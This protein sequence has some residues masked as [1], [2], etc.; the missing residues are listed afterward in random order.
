MNLIYVCALLI[1]GTDRPDMNRSIPNPHGT[2]YTYTAEQIKGL[3]GEILM[4][5]G[6]TAADLADSAT[7]PSW[8]TKQRV[9]DWRDPRK[10]STR[11]LNDRVGSNIDKYLRRS[12]T[13]Y[14]RY[15]LAN[16]GQATRSG[17]LNPGLQPPALGSFQHWQ[18]S[19]DR[20]PGSSIQGMTAEMEAASLTQTARSSKRATQPK[21]PVAPPA[22]SKKALPDGRRESK[23][24]T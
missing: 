1:R 17:D 7:W 8:E 22:Q 13:L 18:S 11:M 9:S 21:T 24:Y 12:S 5:K 6:K 23:K 4:E 16:P 14:E 15:L 10:P 3:V 2:V 19:A 20:P